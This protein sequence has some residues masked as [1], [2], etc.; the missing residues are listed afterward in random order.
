MSLE[1][2]TEIREVE[3]RTERAK[4]EAG[5]RPEAGG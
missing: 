2:I 5:P 4:A 1:A 3:E